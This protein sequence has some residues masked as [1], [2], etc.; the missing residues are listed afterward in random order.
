MQGRRPAGL[1]DG[2]GGGEGRWSGL[3]VGRP[4]VV[5]AARS[6]LR[7]IQAGS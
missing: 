3:A 1:A 6:A 2:G 4:G 5:W 7:V